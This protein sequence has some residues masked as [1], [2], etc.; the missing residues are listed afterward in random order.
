MIARGKHCHTGLLRQV[1]EYLSALQKYVIANEI[2]E[3]VHRE[4]LEQF[5]FLKS[6][7]SIHSEDYENIR[8]ETASLI[9]RIE[10][11]GKRCDDALIAIT[12]SS[13]EPTHLRSS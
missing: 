10:D 13:G 4:L 1:D 6:L 8:S 7:S 2:P 9:L 5:E 12:E 3:S 11:F